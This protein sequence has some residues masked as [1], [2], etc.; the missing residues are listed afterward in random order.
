MD[1]DVIPRDLLA[2]EQ[3]FLP[4]FDRRSIVRVLDDGE[5]RVGFAVLQNAR[6][7]G[8]QGDQTPVG[9]LEKHLYKKM[10]FR[11]TFSKKNH[12]K[13]LLLLVT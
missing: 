5:I 3:D 10:L 11:I 4:S 8:G 1:F 13:V 7:D 2:E 12:G 9:G 6:D